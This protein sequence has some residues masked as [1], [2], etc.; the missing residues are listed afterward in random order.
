MDTI[1][2]GV[3][4]S[5]H[6]QDAIAFA[7]T[8]ARACSAR[9]VVACAFEGDRRERRHEAEFIARRLSRGLHGIDVSRVHA[10]SYP[11]TAPDHGLS[12]LA[13]SEEAALVIVGASRVNGLGD[14]LPGG[15]GA[16]LLHERAYAVA[17]VPRDYV[18]RAD[19]PIRRIGVGYDGTPEARSAL[20]A[21]V[22]A[23]HAFG[24]ELEVIT[25][26]SAQAIGARPVR[27]TGPGYF[28]FDD[29]FRHEANV[30]L[31]AVV[32]SL[33]ISA[34]GTVL[35]GRPAHQLALRSRDLDLLIVGS[36]GY[37]ALRAALGGGVSGRV[38]R[39]AQCP[40]IAVP[41]GRQ[42]SLSFLRVR[43]CADHLS[44]GLGA[45]RA[46]TLA[47]LSWPEAR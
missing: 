16:R 12:E 19:R 26:L 30:Q 17:V 6:S 29:D 34:E 8:I 43:R 39:D 35:D 45:R 2:I 32:G 33:P 38:L 5:E 27:T 37:D 14:A 22:A 42:A 44:G 11:T 25:V 23:V 15:T 36:R 47:G 46:P 7:T 31:D 4:A 18:A 28:D 41:A 13:A 10:R 20:V 24:A 3:D 40:V 1:L 9:V 21:A